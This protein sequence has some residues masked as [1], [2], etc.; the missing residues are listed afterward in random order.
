MASRNT[1]A[2]ILGRLGGKVRSEAKAAASRDNGQLGGRPRI[3]AKHV[4]GA[5]AT[6]NG[7]GRYVR[8][9]R[10]LAN[11]RVE[12]TNSRSKYQPY[13]RGETIPAEILAAAREHGVEIAPPR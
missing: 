7:D 4:V 13:R 6:H 12:R 2:A 1:A 9:W 3:I 10:L 5:L 11:G 8:S